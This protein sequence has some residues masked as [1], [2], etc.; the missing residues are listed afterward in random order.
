MLTFEL[1]TEQHRVL[2]YLDCGPV[3]RIPSQQASVDG[4]SSDLV[5]M[6]LHPSGGL[7]IHLQA[8]NADGRFLVLEHYSFD[9]TGKITG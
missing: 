6:R 8:V 4:V 5:R 9:L 3:H 1:K 7:S 2:R